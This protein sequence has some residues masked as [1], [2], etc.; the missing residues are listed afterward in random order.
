[1]RYESDLHSEFQ[2]LFFTKIF[3]QKYKKTQNSELRIQNY[4]RTQVSLLP[5]PC[6]E[7]TTSEPFFRATLVNPPGVT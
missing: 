6:E 1:M 4:L 5:P 2:F 7:F 3:V